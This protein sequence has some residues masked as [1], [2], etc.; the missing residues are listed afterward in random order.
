MRKLLF[1]LLFFCSTASVYGQRVM[2]NLDRGVVAV[3][4]TPDSVFISWRVLATEPENLP[5]NLYR[6][7]GSGKPV[8]L[9]AQPLTGGT[10]FIDTKAD[11]AQKT[12]Y[13][14]KALVNGKETAGSKPFVIPANAPVSQYLSIPLKTPAGYRPHDTSVGDLDGDGEYELVL[15]QVGKGLDN[16]FNGFTDKPILQAYKLNGT[17][18]WTI[19]LGRNIR[20][21]EHYTQFIVMDLDGD[22]KAEVAMKT[23]DGTIDGQGKVIGDSTKDYRSKK[24]ATLGK[25]LDGPEFFTVFDGQTGAALATTDYIPSRYPTDGWGGP[26]GNGGNDNSGNRVDRFLACAAYLDGKLPSVVMCRGY[27]GRTVLAAW[28]YRNGKLTSR[29]VF[30]TKDGKNPFSGQGNHNLTVADVDEDGKDEIVYGSMVV[31]DNGKGLFSTGFRHGDALHV[32]DLDLDRPGL[33]VFG[34]HE[35][36][37]HAKGDSGYV[38]DAGPGVTV[39]SARTGE[40]SFKGAIDTDVGAGVAENI[41]PDNAGAEMWWSGSGGLHSM[42]GAKIGPTPTASWLIWWDGDFTRELMGGGRISK[43]KGGTIFS[44]SGAR[45]NGRG[46][47][48]LTADLFGDWREEFILSAGTNELR[49]YTTVLATK[50]RLYTLMH[51]PQYRLSI[52]WQNVAYNQPPHLGFYLGED[53]KK[54]PKPKIVLPKGANTTYK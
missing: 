22:G 1:Y 19:D 54:A 7:T 53:M 36:E 10:N 41:D 24:P 48:N 37:D 39:Y 40:V 17:L 21:G 11:V 34:P 52:A 27:Y 29:W 20:E 18:L 12:A 31:D 35:I 50:H 5:F 44:A 42:K 6:T 16:S 3:R 4:H 47:P 43:Y 26:G 45:G 2:E 46:N 28:D 13:T 23:A 49:I 15:H 33:E 30:D 25:V 9:N 51:D 38:K 14:V 8:K 32:S